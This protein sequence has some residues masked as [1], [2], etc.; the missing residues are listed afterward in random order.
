M[1][2]QTEGTTHIPEVPIQDLNVSMNYL[3]CY[4]FV[5]ALAYP[6]DEK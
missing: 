3:Q 2:M 6:A 5:V 1:L 4:Q